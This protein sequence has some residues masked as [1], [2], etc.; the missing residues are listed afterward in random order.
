MRELPATGTQPAG[1]GAKLGKGKGKASTL[2]AELGERR[3]C[4]PQVNILQEVWSIPQEQ[5]PAP[6]PW[7]C[8]RWEGLASPHGEIP[9]AVQ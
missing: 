7:K 1:N 3:G 5:H 8:Q 2:R 4:D 9:C 6:E